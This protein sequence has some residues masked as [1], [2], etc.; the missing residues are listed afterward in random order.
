MEHRMWSSLEDGERLV[1][2]W[3]ESFSAQSRIQRSRFQIHT[4]D[5]DEREVY[6]IEEGFGDLRDWESRGRCYMF[7]ECILALDQE[8][9]TV[10]R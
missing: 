2:A 4:L 1:E 10:S 7:D 9:E 8:E 5:N 3:R 6:V